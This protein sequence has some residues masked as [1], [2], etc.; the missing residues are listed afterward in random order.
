MKTML[1][2]R[3]TPWTCMSKSTC[4]Y[5]PQR[6]TPRIPC[7]WFEVARSAVVPST[8]IQ[9]GP[10]VVG[11]TNNQ[12]QGMSPHL[13]VILALGHNPMS[14]P[15]QWSKTECVAM[16]RAFVNIYKRLDGRALPHEVRGGGGTQHNIKWV[17]L[18]VQF[19]SWNVS[20]LALPP[21][22]I[23]MTS[24]IELHIFKFHKWNKFWIVKGHNTMKI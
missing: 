23:C 3:W 13:D 19:A 24:L 7:G 12:V 5:L 16:G 2:F 1:S 20:V 22:W 15:F 18:V 6:Q 11:C 9:G 4:T 17:C 21:L 14:Q 8:I 10:Y